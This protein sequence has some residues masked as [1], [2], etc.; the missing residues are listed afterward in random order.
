MT[1]FDA[2]TA[3]QKHKLT[4]PKRAASGRKHLTVISRV[5]GP[6]AE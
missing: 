4:D 1:Y 6:G 5:A 2:M 3:A